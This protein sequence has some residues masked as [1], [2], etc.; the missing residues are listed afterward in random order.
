MSKFKIVVI[1]SFTFLLSF[2]MTACD[3]GGQPQ[4]HTC[5]YT[6]KT[7][8][9]TCTEQGYTQYFCQECGNSYN[10]NY[11][12]AKGHSFGEWEIKVPATEDQ[13]G[14]EVQTCQV[15]G[16]SAEQEIPRLE[17]THK[18]SS[19]WSF[20][21]NQHWYA[22]TCGHADIKAN[23]EPH[24]FVDFIEEV[25]EGEY[26]VK[27]NSLY[28]TDCQYIKRGEH[29]CEYGSDYEYDALTHWYPSTCGHGQRIVHHTLSLN[30]EK[31]WLREN[32]LL[33]IF[34]KYVNVDIL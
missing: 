7:I 31:L 32:M 28:C 9:P 10:D 26:I 3:G 19:E 22:A 11:V 14:L 16:H 25:Q 34:H 18:Y 5:Q 27:Y 4:Q 30:I 12:P 29:E 13:T 33:N 8:D 20:N 2:V 21:E 1:L 6:T 24:K 23:E 17:H 15:C